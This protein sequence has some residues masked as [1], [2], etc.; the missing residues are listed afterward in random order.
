MVHSVAASGQ[1]LALERSGA[2]YRELTR[3]RAPIGSGAAADL[4]RHRLRRTLF[5]Q[6][7]GRRLPG[8]QADPPPALVPG[9][10]GRPVADRIYEQLRAEFDL[11][12]RYTS[13]EL[14]LRSVQEALELVTDVAR[15]RRLV[16]L[17][18]S[19]VMLIVLEIVLEIVLSLVGR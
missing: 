6:G 13:L 14:K 16:L 12:D 4:P 15:D 11:V 5:A 10:L 1:N 8:C 2:V 9:D 19:I 3:H 17:E 7:A 18:A